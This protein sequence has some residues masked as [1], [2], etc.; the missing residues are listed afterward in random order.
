MTKRANKTQ[1]TKQLIPKEL[2]ENQATYSLLEQLM[3]YYNEQSLSIKSY[4]QGLAK[5][6]LYHHP[7]PHVQAWIQSFPNLDTT[8]DFDKAEFK[9]LG[10]LYQSLIKEGEKNKRGMYYTPK[11]VAQHLAKDIELTDNTRILD[12]ACGTGNLLLWIPNV[13]P[14]HIVGFDI[15][16]IALVIAKVNFYLQFPYYDGEA[17]FYHCDFLEHYHHIP[18]YFDTIVA[19]PPW[20]LKDK[21]KLRDK[22]IQSR[23]S[24]ALFFKHAAS[25]IKKK[26]HLHFLFPKSILN[27]RVHQDLR[28]FILQ[29]MKINT[30][31]VFP[32]QFEG[33]FTDSVA[34]SVTKETVT[35]DYPITYTYASLT[36]MTIYR[37][38]FDLTEPHYFI[39][40]TEQEEALIM[41]FFNHGTH[42]LSN[43]TFAL[44]IVTGNNKV[45]LK[46]TP[47]SE[48]W[49]AIYRGSE[50]E[51]YTLSTNRYF[52]QYNRENYQQVA[53]EAIYRA[54]QKLVYKFISRYPVIA[55][56][57]KQQ[58]FLNSVNVLIPNIEGLS[59]ESVMAL[60]NSSYYRFVYTHLF[61]DCKVLKSNLTALP[62]PNLSEEENNH[63]T[64][65]VRQYIE[66]KDNTLLVEIDRIINDLYQL[67]DD[68]KDILNNE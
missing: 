4:I 43:A 37:R 20:G 55:L 18:S 5:Q 28:T 65:L 31:S 38:Y 36:L 61:D 35:G 59:I 51:A 9:V 11:H 60:M 33:V 24:F 29:N 41:N 42:N 46:E 8:F 1:S 49:E 47:Q 27:V 30:L 56:D 64:H 32:K 13:Q 34:L 62:L 63:L 6:L 21:E 12:P 14:Y 39:A 25:I 57:D 40:L 15:D 67:S 26:G 44:G 45:Y 68:D 66:T 50:V 52:I 10:I 54:P 7:Q 3:A 22:V 48:S 17:P 16:D 2:I 19:N 58:L 23:E 53:P